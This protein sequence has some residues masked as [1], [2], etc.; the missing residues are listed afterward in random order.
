MRKLL[1]IALAAL[2]A[3]LIVSPSALAAGSTKVTIQAQTSGFFGQVKSNKEQ[4]C[5][6]GRKVKLFKVKSGKDKKIGSDIAQANGDGYMWSIGA[7]GGGDYYAK[8][9]RVDGCDPGKSK[10][11][12]AQN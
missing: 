3:L 11:I 4:K 5:A 8:A 1:V 7:S 6:N 12:P 10:T 2:T 9:G